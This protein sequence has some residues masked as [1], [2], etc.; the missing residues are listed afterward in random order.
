MRTRPFLDFGAG[1]IRRAVDRLP[2]QGDRWPWIATTGYAQDIKLLRRG[3]VVEPE[4]DLTRRQPAAT[5]TARAG[6]PA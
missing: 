3:R 1:Y 4:L 5:S 6:G 2:R